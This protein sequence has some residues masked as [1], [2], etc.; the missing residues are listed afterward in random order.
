MKANCTLLLCRV[1]R[2][3]NTQ[4]KRVAFN[5]TKMPSES[6]A[7]GEVCCSATNGTGQHAACYSI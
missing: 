2:V 5:V 4:T 1:L 7:E 6:G 3:Y